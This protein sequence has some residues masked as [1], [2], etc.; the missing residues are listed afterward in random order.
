VSVCNLDR[1]ASGRN[2]AGARSLPQGICPPET[3]EA[4]EAAGGGTDLGAVLNG[5]R[6]QVGVHREI[7]CRAG[8]LQEPAQGVE[9]T[10][11]GV[12]ND[13]TWLSQLTTDY[14]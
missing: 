4:F 10:F 5:E 1:A 14:V 12:Q 2:H 11:S 9:V 6:S 3:E 7:A 8:W 13:S